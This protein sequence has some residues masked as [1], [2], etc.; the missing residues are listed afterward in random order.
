M[1]GNG[2]QGGP[3]RL[4]GRDR[5]AAGLWTTRIGWPGIFGGRTANALFDA[6][7][8]QVAMER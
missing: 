7:K 6:L 2:A 4:L 5:I 3:W 1:A 8:P